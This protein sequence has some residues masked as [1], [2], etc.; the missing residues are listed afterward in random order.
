MPARVLRVT[1]TTV[2]AMSGN[3]T[4]DS[5]FYLQQ[6]TDRYFSTQN[7]SCDCA[8]EAI[9][10]G[11]FMSTLQLGDIVLFAA[12]LAAS[13]I[14]LTALHWLPWNGGTKPLE[15]TTAYALGTL[16]TVG[17]PALT[18]IMTALLGLHY[19]ELFWAALLLV[20]ALV[21]GATVKSCYW[22][23]GT[24]A[25]SLDEVHHGRSAGR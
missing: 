24:R 20:N 2:Q 14:S 16:V 3:R 11:L 13:A 7:E 12:P 22:L 15:R 18:M 25:I 23:D 10:K 1:M 21:S 6:M 17:V 9:L 8:L 19:G 5:T 4:N